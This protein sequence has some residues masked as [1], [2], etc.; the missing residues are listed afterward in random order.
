[1]QLSATFKA[2][3]FLFFFCFFIYFSTLGNADLSPGLAVTAVMDTST[4][5]S[6]LFPLITERKRAAD[7]PRGSGG[8]GLR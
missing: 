2:Y 7:W 5:Q 8:G 4:G 1:M 6:A 3:T